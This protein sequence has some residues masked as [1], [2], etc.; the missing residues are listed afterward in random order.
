MLSIEITLPSFIKRSAAKLI[1]MPL[2]AFACL[3]GQVSAQG[4]TN[5]STSSHGAAPVVRVNT[6]QHW[7]DLSATQ[8]QT[9]QPLNATWETLGENEKR[10]WILVTRNYS[11]LSAA[12]Q[13]KLRNRMTEWAA[14]TPKQRELAR[15]NFAETKKLGAS[16]RSANW[17]A[18]KALSPQERQKLG[19]QAKHK[20]PGAAI[21]VKPVAPNRLVIVPVTR[22]SSETTRARVAAEQPFSAKTL[23]PIA[24]PPQ[25]SPVSPTPQQ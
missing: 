7:V 9:L 10:K 5:P 21:A 23:L 8:Q 19:S 15:L 12:E 3:V 24:A 16:E 25:N 13:E 18:Y 4:P 6:F 20:P 17:E 14:L 22:R 1:C 11:R 2:V